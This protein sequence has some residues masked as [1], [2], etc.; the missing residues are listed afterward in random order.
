VP[1]EYTQSSVNGA[2]RQGE[3]L[4]NI[5]EYRIVEPVPPD[6]S[7]LKAQTIAHPLAIVL[8]AECDL[9][10]D[11]RERVGNNDG[12]PAERSTVDEGRNAILPYALLFSLYP[13]EAVKVRIQETKLWK[14]AQN[15]Q[16]ERYHFVPDPRDIFFPGEQDNRSRLA[17]DFK[18][19]MMMPITNIY[20]GISLGLTKRLAVM[21]AIYVHD[22]MH[23]CYAFL[24]RV[25]LPDL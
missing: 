19:A 9:Y 3:V 16:N 24:S 20:Y 6:Q 22:L 2:L 21:P 8:S 10:W 14:L 23:R 12:F 4:S 25:G 17:I 11:Y 1:L 15:N 18:K 13:P 7:G 5:V